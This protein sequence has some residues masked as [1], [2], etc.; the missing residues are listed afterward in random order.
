[1][2]V[3]LSFLIIHMFIFNYSQTS[4]TGKV[5]DG[6][7]ELPISNVEITTNTNEK[8]FTNSEGKFYLNYNGGTVTFQNYNYKEE[9]IST[10]K[11]KDTIQ[12]MSLKVT[13]LDN[14]VVENFQSKIKQIYKKAKDNYPL[15]PYSESFFL[16]GTQ[17]RNNEFL[18]IVDLAGNLHR[19]T[20]FMTP[21]IKKIQYEVDSKNIRKAGK[22]IKEENFQFIF[23]SLKQL[24]NKTISIF[25]D[26]D[27]YNFYK[28]EVIDSLYS[29][30]YFTAKENAT[31]PLEGYYIINNKDM[32]IVSAQL[33]LKEGA[34]GSILSKSDFKWQTIG[35]DMTVNFSYNSVLK[36]YTPSNCVLKYKVEL[37]RKGIQYIYDLD[38]QILFY[39]PR[40]ADISSNTSV[41]KEIFEI[42]AD[43]NEEFWKKQNQ[44]LLTQEMKDF[45]NT[46]QDNKEYKAILN[47]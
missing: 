26:L 46:L 38:Y 22:I 19:S 1:M 20:L 10:L 18:K 12:L 7:T 47:K 13:D 40:Q 3:I 5:I 37:S 29:K 34:K 45:I 27:Y 21:E 42:S 9:K 32:A 41:N 44:L 11:D 14:V 25:L 31:Y 6:F 43:Y 30:M 2:K 39:N 24:L 17:K 35:Q 33:D 16:R 23:F 8:T 15:F 36:K 4:I 28:T